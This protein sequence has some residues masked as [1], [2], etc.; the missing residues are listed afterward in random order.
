MRT[1]R[2]WTIAGLKRE[3][4][5]VT[6]TA[7]IECAGNGRA[8]FPQPAGTVLWRHGAVGC[9]R[10]T[11]VRL[12]DLLRQCELLP[13]AVYTGH[14]SPD[15]YLDGS[16]PA[17][18]RGLPI[19]KALAPETLVAFALNGEPL[20]VLHGGPLRLV[21][22]GYPGASF[23]KWLTRIEVRD[24]EHDGE[25][26]MDGHYRMPRAPLRYG[27]PFDHAQF[28]IITD[29]P[30]KSL[31][32]APREGF[33]ATA[34][35]PLHIRGH[36]WSGH[37][38]VETV[39]LSFDGGGSWRAA[40]LGPAADRFAWRRFSFTLAG[41]PR[42]AI[43]IIARATDLERPRA[44]V[45]KRAMESARLLQQHVPPGAGDMSDSGHSRRHAGG[46]P[47]GAIPES[48][49]PYFRLQSRRGYV[50]VRDGRFA[51]A[52][53]TSGERRCSSSITTTFRCARRRS[54]SCWRKRTSRGRTIT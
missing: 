32:T 5:T 49:T 2:A 53:M 10:W 13:Q 8:F 50:D 33:S 20:P 19:D 26:M 54:A 47:K 42:G 21:A 28:E 9:V 52:G 11:G 18:S 40:S 38:P 29:M 51:S 6:E 1:P 24:R 17:I 48:I 16:G 25:R 35:E 30:V 12:G 27:E 7:V 31:I 14:H 46:A 43:E 45:G 37:T 23:Q 39:E 41:P 44:T 15:V 34:S 22:P 3:F 4:E 36:A